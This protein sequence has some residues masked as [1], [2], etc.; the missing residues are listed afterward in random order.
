MH[1]PLQGSICAPRSQSQ[2]EAKVKAS[3]THDQIMQFH[4]ETR[5]RGAL[6]ALDRVKVRAPMNGLPRRIAH[7]KAPP[8]VI[9][10]GADAIS[11]MAPP[12]DK[13]GISGRACSHR[14]PPPNKS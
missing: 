4:I 5:L 8:T 7:E 6:Y 12:V 11:P 10:D 14:R 3:A 13:R 1:R 9:V 2:T